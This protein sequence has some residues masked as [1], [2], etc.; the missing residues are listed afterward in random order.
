MRI[1][2]NP[3]YLVD[4]TATSEVKPASGSKASSASAAASAL[5]SSNTV[6]R[7]MISGRGQF[8]EQMKQ[9]LA[10]LPDV[11]LDKVALAKQQLQQGGYPVD[12][13]VLA[14]KLLE[15]TGRG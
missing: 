11:R 1:D 6:D 4:L 10:S 14:Q 3:P 5:K 15:G 7:S 8:I 12:S 9:Q 13:G 2:G